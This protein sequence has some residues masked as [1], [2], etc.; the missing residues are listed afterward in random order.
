[1]HMKIDFSSERQNQQKIYSMENGIEFAINEKQQTFCQKP[2]TFFVH[3][4]LDS[5]CSRM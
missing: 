5:F 4:K 3:F 1:M 2:K